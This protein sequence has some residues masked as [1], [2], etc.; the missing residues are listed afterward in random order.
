MP[1]F[2][3]EI[4]RQGYCFSFELVYLVDLNPKSIPIKYFP[5]RLCFQL[6]F[7]FRSSPVENHDII[8]YY[9]NKEVN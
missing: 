7:H 5:H 6:S 1:R 4:C 2:F 8:V 9:E 3:L